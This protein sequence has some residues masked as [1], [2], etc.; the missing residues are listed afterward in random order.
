MTQ[1]MEFLGKLF[2]GGNGGVVGKVLDKFVPDKDKKAQIELELKMLLHKETELYFKDIESARNMQSE[3]LKQSDNFSKRFV[4]YLSIA[5]FLN[6]VLA[7][8]LSI[9]I[10]YPKA[11]NDM[12]VMYYTVSFTFGAQQ[13]FKFFFGQSKQ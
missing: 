11:N 2:G 5:V 6:M 10:E 1:G 3:A 7:G 8:L 13:V 4:Y 12:V 9:F